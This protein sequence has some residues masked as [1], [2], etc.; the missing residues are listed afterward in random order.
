MTREVYEA[1]KPRLVVTFTR[2]GV[3]TVDFDNSGLNDGFRCFD[4]GYID[5]I[6]VEL[7]SRRF[8]LW[9]AA[10]RVRRII[11]KFAPDCDARLIANPWK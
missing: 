2:L 6:K 5:L 9:N 10:Q 7:R 8:S 11:R 4:D 3:A 1:L